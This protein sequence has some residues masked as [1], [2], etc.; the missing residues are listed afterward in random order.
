MVCTEQLGDASDR[1]RPKVIITDLEYESIEP[2]LVL[3]G[4]S[5]RARP[6]N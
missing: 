3:D 1:M 6:E 4:S 2:E 5:V